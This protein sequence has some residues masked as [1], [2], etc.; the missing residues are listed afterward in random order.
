VF[1]NDFVK[2]TDSLKSLVT[3]SE[4]ATQLGNRNSESAGKRRPNGQTLTCHREAFA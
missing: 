2:N 1:V 3:D 4:I